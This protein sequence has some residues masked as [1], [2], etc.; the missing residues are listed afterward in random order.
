MKYKEFNVKFIFPEKNNKRFGDLD[1][2]VKLPAP[3][4]RLPVDGR[5]YSLWNNRFLFLKQVVS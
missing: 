3:I 2:K 5:R 4:I 1:L